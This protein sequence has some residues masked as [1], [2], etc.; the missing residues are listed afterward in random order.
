MRI[1]PPVPKNRLFA[2]VWTILTRFWKFKR[3]LKGN[4][5]FYTVSNFYKHR[6]KN[7]STTGRGAKAAQSRVFEQELHPILTELTVFFMF[8]DRLQKFFSIG[9]H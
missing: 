6:F 9:R 3:H 5:S 1:L 2:L 4:L 8:L 7:K